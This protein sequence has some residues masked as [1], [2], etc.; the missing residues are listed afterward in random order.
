M[1]S[2]LNPLRRINNFIYNS[3]NIIEQGF[4]KGFNY[5]NKNLR[6]IARLVGNES[7]VD[8]IGDVGIA[9]VKIKNAPKLVKA[10]AETVK[11]GSNVLSGVI[12]R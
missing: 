6:N 8:T 10:A 11:G 3:T 12:G 5:A 4:I 9:G 7:I 1:F 2:F